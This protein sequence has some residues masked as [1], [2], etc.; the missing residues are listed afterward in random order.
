MRDAYSIVVQSLSRVQL[1]VT[2]WTTACQAS[3]S[4]TTSQRLLKLMTIGW[5]MPSNHLVFCR[6][7]L[8]LPSVFSSLGVFSN[9]SALC[10][11][12]PEYWRRE[13][14]T[15]YSILALRTLWTVWKGIF[16]KRSEKRE[17]T[18][19]LWWKIT[20]TKWNKI[21]SLMS[22]LEKKK[23]NTKGKKSVCH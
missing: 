7:S 4:F 10:I 9:E 17:R 22:C 11:R 14:Q 6:P 2:P 3:L 19:E 12:W 20:G 15:T 5:V 23:K 1:F 13:W 16:Y 21:Q 8:L 18:Y